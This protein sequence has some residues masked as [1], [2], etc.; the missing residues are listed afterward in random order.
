MIMCVCHHLFLISIPPYGVFVCRDGRTM[1][2]KLLLLV[3]M[4][5]LCSSEQTHLIIFFLVVHVLS[6]SFGLTITHIVSPF[7]GFL[8]TCT[9][10]RGCQGA[11]SFWCWSS[12][13][14][15][16]LVQQPCMITFFWS[17]MC[18]SL[19]SY[20]FITIFCLIISN[21]SLL[22]FLMTISFPHCIFKDLWSFLVISTLFMC[23]EYL[24][25]FLE[26]DD[27]IINMHKSY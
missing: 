6:P 22:S 7:T 16:I 14:S 26:M 21:I 23:N 15:F 25:K 4:I 13:F 12:L 9:K 27:R 24:L 19:L 3:V 11:Q 20:D 17:C 1:S 10:Q 5:V 2:T 8:C 18:V